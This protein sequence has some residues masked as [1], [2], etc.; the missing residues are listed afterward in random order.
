MT[1]P[2]VESDHR[3]STVRRS[4]TWLGVAAI[5]LAAVSQADYVA[6]LVHVARDDPLQRCASKYDERSTDLRG[7][8]WDWSWPGW[9]CQFASGPD[10]HVP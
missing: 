8:E 7:I 4:V 6:E 2:Q 1:D 5:A 9:T 10:G 3:P